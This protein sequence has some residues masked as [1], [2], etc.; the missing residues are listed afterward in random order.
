MRRNPVLEIGKRIQQRELSDPVDLRSTPDIQRNQLH[1]TSINP[2]AL[3]C[4]C[5][6]SLGSSA[7]T[8]RM[9][10]SLAGAH[11]LLGSVLQPQATPPG[12]RRDISCRQVLRDQSEL[13][14]VIEEKLKEVAVRGAMRP[15]NISGSRIL[16]YLE[17]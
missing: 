14:K 9:A 16:Q 3:L 2:A 4:H 8:A 6:I 5:P 11:G 15:G 17:R 1:N 12:N 7:F 10:Y 13:R